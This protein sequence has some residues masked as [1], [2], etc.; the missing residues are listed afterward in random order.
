MSKSLLNK[1]RKVYDS[2]KKVSKKADRYG[3]FEAK[4]SSAEQ[5]YE[6]LKG[7]RETTPD[8]VQCAL[9]F[10][11]TPGL[12][13]MLSDLP[14]FL[15]VRNHFFFIPHPFTSLSKFVPRYSCLL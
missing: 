8:T 1:K 14:W 3:L 15:I 11:I 10:K 12:A 13:P 4:S 6:E 7:R 9:G 5:D 2:E